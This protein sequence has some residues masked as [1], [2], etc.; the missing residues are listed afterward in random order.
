[1][2]KKRLM[3]D[4]IQVVPINETNNSLINL[5][6]GQYVTQCKHL[7]RFQY[8]KYQISK[9]SH[10]ILATSSTT[11]RHGGKR[12]KVCGF[13]LYQRRPRFGYIDVVCS[14]SRYG[15]RLIQQA[16][17]LTEQLG[18][19]YIQLSALNHVIPYYTNKGYRQVDNPC[20]HTNNNRI[21]RKGSNS[22]GWRM[23]KCLN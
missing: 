21:R 6:L 22:N 14:S 2:I 5:I 8:G 20:I 23:T 1:M 13:L 4:S 19:R 3:C 7:V 15:S 17:Q 12:T 16:E 9:A 11:S 18:L 10:I